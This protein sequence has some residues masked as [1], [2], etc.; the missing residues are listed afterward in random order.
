MAPKIILYTAH[1][2]PFAHRSQIVL[3]E[4]G[5]EFETVLVDIT[6]PRTPEYLAINP[7]GMVPALTYDNLVL[8]ES[9][10]ISQFLVDSHPSHLLKSSSEPAG[11]LQRFNIGYFVDTYFSKA[12]PH[13]DLAVQSSGE[14]ESIAAANK[15]IDAVVIDIEPLL[16]DAAP[17]FGGSRRPTLAEV[18][19]GSFLLRV[20]SLP[21]HEDMA[22]SFIPKLLEE[23]A[24]NF[25]RWGHAVMAENSVTSVWDEE[26]VVR[27]TREKIDNIRKRKSAVQ[28]Q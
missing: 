28:A 6:I 17:F 5:L 9:G 22:P 18:Q 11:A 27:R 12:Q 3:R 1:H 20:F 19:T 14:A 8:T 26:L 4:L 10:L 25:W 21:K 2:C 23:R 24:P 16:A 13:F 7:R 15:Y